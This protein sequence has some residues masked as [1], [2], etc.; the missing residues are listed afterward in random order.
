[1][2]TD[3]RLVRHSALI[4]GTPLSPPPIIRRANPA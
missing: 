4:D 3:D 1:V 2:I